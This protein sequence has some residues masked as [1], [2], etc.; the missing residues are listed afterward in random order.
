MFFLQRVIATVFQTGATL[1]ENFTIG[2]VTEVIVWIVRVIEQALIVK[3]V[4]K[5]ITSMKA[6]TALPVI[7]TKSVSHFI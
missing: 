5:I 4:E 1:I 6:V 3:D 2:P 7:A